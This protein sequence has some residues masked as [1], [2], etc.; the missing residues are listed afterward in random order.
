[1]V[2]VSGAVFTI[3]TGVLIVQL[4]LG[5]LK[6]RYNAGDV[7]YMA[8]INCVVRTLNAD[9]HGISD[10][11]HGYDNIYLYCFNYVGNQFIIAIR[12]LRVCDIWPIYHG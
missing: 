5:R 2:R 10:L 3:T 9:S 1:L 6:L 4:I 8:I 11:Y 7:Y 12:H